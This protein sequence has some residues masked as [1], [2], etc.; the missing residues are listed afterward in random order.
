MPGRV[1]EAGITSP[2]LII[3]GS[4]VKLHTKLAWYEAARNAKERHRHS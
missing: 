4:V 1:A 3:V 2:A